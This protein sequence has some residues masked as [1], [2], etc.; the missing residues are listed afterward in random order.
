MKGPL[1][2]IYMVV[3]SAV[4]L[5]KSSVI[6]Y[7]HMGVTVKS[8][9]PPPGLSSSSSVSDSLPAQRLAP[10]SDQSDVRIHDERDVA[11]VGRPV[12]LRISHPFLY[13]NEQDPRRQEGRG[14]ECPPQQ[15][16]DPEPWT[17][18]GIRGIGRGAVAATFRVFPVAHDWRP[19]SERLATSK[20][21]PAC[22]WMG[23]RSVSVAT[24]A[25]GVCLPGSGI[26]VIADEPQ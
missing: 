25:R 18:V 9:P 26:D 5:R 17:A 22:R 14:T 21:T 10:S 20:R 16:G 3:A 11:P 23:D 4:R 8:I 7:A 24:G 19:V 15:V 12:S 2:D 1:A 6:D 13:E